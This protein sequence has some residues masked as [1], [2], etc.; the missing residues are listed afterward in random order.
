MKHFPITEDATGTSVVLIK[1]GYANLVSLK[2]NYLNHGVK[3]LYFIELEYFDGKTPAKYCKEWIKEKLLPLLKE[4]STCYVYC[5]DSAYFKYLTGLKTSID[6]F[7]SIHT[8]KD[9]HIKIV[10]GVNYGAL[11]Y[12]PVVTTRNLDISLKTFY[13]AITAPVSTDQY[14]FIHSA[15]YPRRKE[16]RGVLEA[17]LNEPCIAVDIETTS[18]KVHEAE[19]VSICFCRDKHNGI[20]FPVEDIQVLKDF[21]EEYQGKVIYHN[22]S[23]DVSVLIYRL[24][25]DSPRDIVGL[26]K[27]L[28]VLT[29]NFEDTW[30]IAHLCLNSTARIGLGLK[31]LALEHSGQYALEEIKDVLS[32]PMPKLLLYNLIDGLNT[33]F[34]YQKY[35]PLLKEEDQVEQ[36]RGI[37]LNSL[38]AVIYMQL[39]GLHIDMEKVQQ[40]KNTLQTKKDELEVYLTELPQVQEALQL[41]KESVLADSNKKLKVKKHTLDMPKYSE[42]TFNFNSSTQ[43]QILL[44]DVMQ[45]P[46][47][48]TTQAGAPAT[49]T[50]TLK[51]MI[52][53][54]SDQDNILTSLVQLKNINI[55]LNNFIPSFEG[56]IE[57][58]EGFF[59]HGSF[60]LTGVPSGRTSSSNPNLQNIPSGST[61]GKAIKECFTS[62]DDWVF[63]GADFSSLED[64]INTLLTRDENKMK[65]Y[66]EGFDGHSLRAYT[67]FKEAMPEIKQAVETDKCYRIGDQVV[68]TG[69]TIK[70]GEGEY[71]LEQFI[72]QF[73][74]NHET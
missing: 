45:Y 29:K 72:E 14:D 4:L 5:A 48:N 1:P 28:D 17:L 63:C 41:L 62:S 36:Y 52:K 33:Q 53:E 44:Y 23:Y 40:L 70:F 69:D 20:A 61:Y 74:V 11:I 12:N 64:R 54:G 43:L 25:M 18:L 49:D 34:L 59:L 46:V 51:H 10:C 16:I 39:C 55:I 32:V 3:S 8:I 68:K 6:A 73:G 56:S 38:K 27:G 37:F 30:I 26:N 71:T 58:D 21:F 2:R 60:N 31:S 66:L 24:Y 50:K 35:L 65:I 19:L 57:T 22:A 9:T 7:A 13:K 15:K 47:T 42:M 67:Y